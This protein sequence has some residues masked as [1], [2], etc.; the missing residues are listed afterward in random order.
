MTPQEA[1]VW[2]RQFAYWGAV[3][4][5]L[6]IHAADMFGAHLKLGEFGK[7]IQY[8]QDGRYNRRL[9]IFVRR[10]VR[11]VDGYERPVCGW[12]CDMGTVPQKE[13]PPAYCDCAAGSALLGE[14][15][16]PRTRKES[17]RDRRNLIATMGIT[18]AAQRSQR[19]Q[20]LRRKR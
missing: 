19:W 2:L 9:R 3:G 16:R 6:A 12:C 8:A 10:I 4:D 7:T 14:H 17:E 5:T 18:T 11:M 13:G 1:T 15:R 20:Q